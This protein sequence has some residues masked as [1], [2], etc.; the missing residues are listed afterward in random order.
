MNK[1]QKGAFYE[2]AAVKFLENNGVIILEK[3]YRC[4]LGEI[5]IIGIDNDALVFFEVKYRTGDM[6]GSPLE[7]ID[8]RK[9]RKII[10]VAKYYLAYKNNDKFIRFDAIGIDREKIDWVKNAFC[11]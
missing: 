4:R 11:M 8:V 9:Q 3:N 7:A 2:D 1:R 6:F 5:D 10:S